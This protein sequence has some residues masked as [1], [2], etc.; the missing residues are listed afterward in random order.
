MK[1]NTE[2]SRALAIEFMAVTDVEKTGVTFFMRNYLYSYVSLRRIPGTLLE[3][4]DTLLLVFLLLASA[5][6]EQRL[7][8]KNLAREFFSI[9]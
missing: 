8:S 1:G 6:T 9:K 4:N 3:R 5:F 7:N 2:V